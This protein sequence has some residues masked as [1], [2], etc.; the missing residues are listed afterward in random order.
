VQWVRDEVAMTKSD[1]QAQRFGP[2]EHLMLRGEQA[3]SDAELIAVLLGT[4]S[5]SDPVGVLA[6][7]LIERT[8][9]LSGLRRAGLSAMSACPG[10][11]ATKACRLR[12]ALELG[13]R[14]NAAPLHPLAPISQSSD[15]AAALGPRLR[16]AA[17]EHFFALAL[18]AK[19]RPVAEILVAVGGLTACAITP[20]DVFRLVLREPAA[21]V[22]FVHNH[23]SGEPAPSAE[24]VRVTER[25][26]RAGALL[27]IQV[28]DHVILGHG[29]YFSFLDSGLLG[30]E[31][32]GAPPGSERDPFA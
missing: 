25:L 16:S 7:K 8:G 21:G 32:G 27:G 12:A 24:D 26:R 5:A 15:V 10:I 23:P 3:L 19:N 1:E 11:G 29:A 4:G 18:D 22:I 28:L 31:G 2:R 9:G 20:A 30:A 6:Q 17:R 14:M 13:V